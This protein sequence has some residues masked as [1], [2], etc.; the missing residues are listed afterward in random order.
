VDSWGNVLTTVAACGV[1]GAFIDFYIGKPGQRR[2]RGW[3]ETWWI[4]LSYVRWGNF[5]R[6]EALFA[7]EVID[8]LFGRRLLSARRI[9]AVTIVISGSLIVTLV[10]FFFQHWNLFEFGVNSW[11]N[12]L[13][14][15]ILLYFLITLVSTAASFSIARFVAT[16]VASIIIGKPFL[17]FIISC[18]LLL[19]QYLIL[20]WW[21]PIIIA[22]HNFISGIPLLIEFDVDYH[23]T[24]VKSPVWVTYSPPKILRSP[25]YYLSHPS[26]PISQIRE[27]LS[28]D[29]IYEF[30][31]QTPGSTQYLI[32]ILYTIV[33]LSLMQHFCG[34]AN[35]IPNLI[36]FA[37]TVIFVGSFFLRPLQRPIMTLWARVVE[38]DKPVFT[39]LF[40]STAVLAKV[41]QEISEA[42]W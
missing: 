9:I 38:S 7:V 25:L 6:Q 40:G 28:F 2:V 42:L 37:I 22:M 39:L 19:F 24:Y 3:L 17:N 27:I 14:L 4:R 13:K 15:Y 33:P 20:T 29:D 34:L 1:A 10:L 26:S 36:R 12:F 23:T 30:F 31:A 5:G 16:R 32:V 11:Q 21:S 35:I 8:W 41:I 18:F